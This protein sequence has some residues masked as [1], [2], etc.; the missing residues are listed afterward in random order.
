MAITSFKGLVDAEEAGQ[1]FFG[2]F[3]KAV[4]SATGQNSWF[5]TTLS[6]GNPL[7]FYYAS[8]PLIGAS[9]GQAV[10]GGIPHNPPVASLGYK[11]YLKTLNVN[12]GTSGGSVN[13]IMLLMDY[14]FYYPFIDTGITDPQTL[15]NTAS[16]TRYT[17]GAG[18][19]VMAVQL[20]GML[21]T[22]NPTFRFTYINQAGVLQT[23]PT[24]TCGSSSLVGEL[25]TGNNNA[26]SV[27][28]SNYPFLALMPGDTGVRSIQ[29]VT[30]DAPDIG[31]LAFV[32]VKPIEHIA[33]RETGSGAERTPAID[34]FDMPVIA[35]N[36][37]LSLLV[38]T[39]LVGAST[40]PFF[41]TIQTVWG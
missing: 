41:G 13:G 10:N 15:I 34:F 8:T 18:V 17:D 25:A 12:P 9:I 5:D 21:G 20:A 27:A 28:N 36:A 39:G 24:Q 19:S 7:P 2:G 22:G 31:L 6:P 30:F 38:N 29:S 1:T 11:T 35:D 37:Y 16:L 33:L 23:S 3:R 32:L 4:N 40:A 14:L 26:A